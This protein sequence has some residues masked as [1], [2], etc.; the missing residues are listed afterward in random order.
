VAAST[1]QRSFSATV[2]GTTT[3]PDHIVRLPKT[4]GTA[5]VALGTAPSPAASAIAVACLRGRAVP[6]RKTEGFAVPTRGEFRT[7]SPTHI[8]GRH[9]A[10][11]VRQ[12]HPFDTHRNHFGARRE[13]RQAFSGAE[14][15]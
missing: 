15:L 13:T 3:H 12:R 9:A 10:G 6:Y 1:P 8:G 5:H 2:S 7:V 14:S 11:S 4:V